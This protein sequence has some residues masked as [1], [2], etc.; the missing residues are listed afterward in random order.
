MQTLELKFN[1]DGKIFAPLKNKYLIATPEEKVRQ[2]FI[3]TLV[4]KYGYDLEQMAQELKVNK[5]Q[6]GTGKAR[7]DIV[8]WKSKEDKRADKRAFIVVELKAD[9]I[10]IRQ[11][12]YYQGANYASWAS[13]T[14]FVTSNLKETRFFKLNKEYLPTNLEEIVG[15]PFAKDI[16]NTKKINDLLTQTK[17]F[18]R[19]EFTKVLQSCHNIIRD[20]DKLGPAESFDEISKILFIKIHYERTDKSNTIFTKHAYEEMKRA[21]ELANKLKKDTIP[22]MQDLFNDTKNAF[23]DDFLFR[24]NE[25]IE[26]KENSFISI[27]HKLERYNLSDTQDDVKGIAFEHFLG[28]TFRGE[29]GQFFTP[30]TLVDFM[31]GVIDP[32]ENEI[33][34]DCTCGS[35]GFLIKAF[36]YIREHIEEDIR[37]QKKKIIDDIYEQS[38]YDNIDEDKKIELNNKISE[39]TDKFNQDLDT[40]RENSRLN[41]LSCNCIYG[42]DANP[43][44]ART[45]KMNMIMHGDGH[46]GIHHHEGLLNVNGIFEER[47]DCIL[48][49]PPFGS[50][51]D[52][53]QLISEEEI[54][55]DD[56]LIAKYTEKYGDRYKEAQRQVSDNVGSPVISLYEVGKLSALTEVIFIDRCL[57]LLKR[58]GRLGIVLPDGVLNNQN[59]KKV[60]EFFEG[61][62]KIV[63]V[64][65]V[66][67]EVFGSSKA[68]VKT[69]LMF[70]KKFTEDEEKEYKQAC[71]NAEIKAKKTYEDEI[72]ELNN[73]IEYIK[74]K[75]KKDKTKEDTANLKAY[76]KRLKE[77]EKEI[78]EKAKPL[79]KE[80]FDYQIAFAKVDKA[81]INNTGGECENELIPV[82]AE[83]KEYESNNHLWDRKEIKYRY[84]LDDKQKLVRSAYVDE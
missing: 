13:A 6:R 52:K 72:R 50:S 43:R 42:V 59:L 30:R 83:F 71:K 80:Y 84:S 56:S 66:P 33:I 55:K 41:N 78:I 15:I 46:G 76:T 70:M 37:E 48:T 11:E 22:Y 2:E 54:F 5:S 20:N 73:L 65:S 12:D 61:K 17:A 7:A 39:I 57:S 9:N 18:T 81:G 8:I 60:R 47:F 40:T 32:K 34:C 74:K 67:Q 24:E 68:T 77:I 1:K 79:I 38:D 16:N 63:F 19:D 75:S 21:Y 58:G 53:T 62:A 45:S 14:F 4:N 36:E 10:K 35:G 44:M 3:C 49:N 25:K 26:I 64:C 27:V 28:K 82:L 69:S 23:K 31:V 29:L 51:V